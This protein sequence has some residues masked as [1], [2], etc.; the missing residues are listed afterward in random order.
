MEILRKNDKYKNGP[1]GENE[2]IAQGKERVQRGLSPHVQK[3]K[4]Y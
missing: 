1:Y 3:F 2:K 4:F